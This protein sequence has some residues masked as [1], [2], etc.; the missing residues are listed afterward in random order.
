MQDLARSRP[1]GRFAE[2]LTR[3]ELFCVGVE[4]IDGV[5]SGSLGGG[6]GS[7]AVGNRTGCAI[8]IECRF[9]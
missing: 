5:R 1:T 3:H 4:L 2:G 9:V 6:E 7:A 8:H